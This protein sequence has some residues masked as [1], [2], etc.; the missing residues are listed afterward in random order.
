MI[1]ITIKRFLT[2]YMVVSSNPRA[3]VGP[4]IKVLNCS[5]VW[6]VMHVNNLDKDLL[7]LVKVTLYYIFPSA[8]S[9]GIYF[10]A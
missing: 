9:V 1:E 4:F 2:L 5:V 3:M 10:H 8:S 7:T 6:K